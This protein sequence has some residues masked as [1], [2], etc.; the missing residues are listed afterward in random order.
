MRKK[1]WG[2]DGE[3]SGIWA[4]SGEPTEME[5]SGLRHLRSIFTV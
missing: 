4:V 2:D 5:I 1:G 3:D